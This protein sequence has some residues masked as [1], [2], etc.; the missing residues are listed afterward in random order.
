MTTNEFGEH[1]IFNS[2]LK[3]INVNKRKAVYFST[4]ET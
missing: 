4:C 3:I 1:Q 2:Y